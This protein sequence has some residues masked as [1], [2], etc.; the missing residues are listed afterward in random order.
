M[1]ANSGEPDQTSRYAASGLVLH[2]LPM[3][4][5]KEAMLKWVKGS[6]ETVVRMHSLIANVIPVNVLNVRKLYSVFLNKISLVRIID[7][8]DPDQ[9]VSSETI[10]SRSNQSRYALFV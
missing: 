5:R 10:C 1:Q 4:H 2:C 8:E 6:G 9:T 3:S 7:K